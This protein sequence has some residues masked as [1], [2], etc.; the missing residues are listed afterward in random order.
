MAKPNAL[1]NQKLCYFQIQKFCRKWL[2]TLLIIVGEYA[3]DNFLKLFD[4][5]MVSR[6]YINRGYE[7]YKEPTA[8]LSSAIYSFTIVVS[9]TYSYIYVI[10]SKNI[11]IPGVWSKTMLQF[12]KEI[13]MKIEK[14][15]ESSAKQDDAI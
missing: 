8:Q 12:A 6:K 10:N 7:L 11:F 13:S 1:A 15:R 4:L 3:L 9:L 5:K 14:E 2:K